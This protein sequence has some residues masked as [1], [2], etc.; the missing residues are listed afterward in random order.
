MRN[1]DYGDR[2][3]EYEFASRTRLVRRVPVI[4]R[5]DGKSFHTFCKRFE[6]PYDIFL[7]DALDAVMVCLCENIQGAKFAERHSD[8]I[9]ILVTDFDTAQTDAY[10]DYQVQKI[11]SVV[12]SMATAEFC[13]RLM[14]LTP[15]EEPSGGLQ[16]VRCHLTLDEKWPCFDARCFNLPENEIPNYFWWRMLDGK[17]NSISMVAQANF[18]HKRLHGKSSDEMQELLFQEKGINWAKLPQRQKIGSICRRVPQ[19]KPIPAGPA[20]GQMVTRNVWKVEDSPSSVTE[21]RE[22]LDSI[23]LVKE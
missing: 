2:I 18:S 19:E 5:A 23:P 9:S 4:I 8:E 1:D 10:F 11:C 7:N 16:K 14:E 21:L 13:R 6:K 15:D 17:R 3:K 22:I 20:K 12:A